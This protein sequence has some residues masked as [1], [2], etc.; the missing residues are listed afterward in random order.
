[1]TCYTSQQHVGRLAQVTDAV[2]VRLSH[3]RPV[4]SPCFESCLSIYPNHIIDVVNVRHCCSSSNR[5]STC[6][7]HAFYWVV[8]VLSFSTLMCSL[9]DRVWT[10]SSGKEALA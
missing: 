1:M 9:E 7:L 6:S 5:L 4:N 8:T 10:L 2:I 3:L